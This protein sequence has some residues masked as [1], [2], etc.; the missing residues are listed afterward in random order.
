MPKKSGKDKGSLTQKADNNEVRISQV[1]NV[2]KAVSAMAKKTTQEMKTTD[3]MVERGAAPPEMARSMN[4]VLGSLKNTIDSLTKGVETA[5]LGTAKA[6]QDA[7][8]QYGNAISEDIKINRQNMVASALATSTPI[9]G[10]FASKFMETGVFK[11]TKDKMSESISNMFKRKSKGGSMPDDFGDMGDMGGGPKIT[12]AKIATQ[13]KKVRAEKKEDTLSAMKIANRDK[14]EKYD[15]STEEKMLLALTAIQGAVGAEFGKFKVWYDRFLIE[16]PFYRRMRT[17]FKV[18]GKTFGM[19]WKAVYFFFRPRGGYSKQLSKAKNPFEA[20]NQNLGAIF[21]QTMPR[22]DAIMIYTKA[23]AEAVRDM[24]NTITGKKYPKMDP[25]NLG[26]TWS[27]AGTTMKLLKKAGR[28]LTGAMMRSTMKLQPG[29]RRSIEEGIIKAL[30]YSGQFGTYMLEG[31]GA[32]KSKLNAMKA[33]SKEHERLMGGLGGVGVAPEAT[34]PV[35]APWMT[36][37]KML[38]APRREEKPHFPKFFKGMG[39]REKPDLIVQ[40]VYDEFRMKRD[41]KRDKQRKKEIN[42]LSESTHYLKAH[43]K[44]EKRR[45]MTNLFGGIWSG[46][47]G[48]LGGGGGGGGIL[49]ILTRLITNPTVL[50]AIGLPALYKLADS[51]LNKQIDLIEDEKTRRVTKKGKKIATRAMPGAALMDFLLK[52]P[53]E[54]TTELT[55]INP[56]TGK[57]DPVAWKKLYGENS[58]VMAKKWK[59]YKESKGFFAKVKGWWDFQSSEIKADLGFNIKPKNII[60]AENVKE[61]TKKYGGEAKD[62]IG[63]KVED[64]N[65]YGQSLLK[66]AKEKTK[67][68]TQKIGEMTPE[69]IKELATQYGVDAKELIGMKYEDAKRYAEKISN[70]QSIKNLKTVTIAQ[71]KE[72]ANKYGGYPEEYYRLTMEQAKKYGARLKE[73]IEHPGKAAMGIKKSA[74]ELKKEY[75][76]QNKTIQSALQKSG[77]YIEIGKGTFVEIYRQGKSSLKEMWTNVA[78]EKKEMVRRKI[79]E[80]LASGEITASELKKM[81]IK[82]TDATME[83]GEKVGKAVVVSTA[84]TIN[85]V[86]SA[87]NNVNNGGGGNSTKMIQ[88]NTMDKIAQGEMMN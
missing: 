14:Y 78:P 70:K 53:V 66:K 61:W 40:S 42:L 45:T 57:I 43:D 82:L 64:A 69:K 67:V 4:S 2:S 16:H 73:E 75:I 9:F 19:A 54:E 6:A 59:K 65:K 51:W 37:K 1:S 23:T 72:L 62:W 38:P 22:L 7:L 63:M 68:V 79:E 87:L 60:T 32:L 41:I 20:I 84:T 31:P 11:K 39:R 35:L 88:E 86:S 34:G 44:R 81:G 17:T 52:S 3:Y 77:E 36:G 24:S 29:K 85:N 80:A 28:A 25:S 13:A 49:G 50:A 55:G 47:T 26:G 74:Y 46:I 10:Y 15:K 76:D 48:L 8:K 12:P 5:T 27:I 71:A 33:S 21:V 18:L 58:D 30:Y 56:E 83:A